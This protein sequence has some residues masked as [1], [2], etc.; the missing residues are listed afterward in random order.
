MAAARLLDLRKG[1][2]N[3]SEAPRELLARALGAVSARALNGEL[4]LAYGGERGSARYLRALRSFLGAAEPSSPSASSWLLTTSGCSHG[5]ELLASLL[6]RRGDVVVCES[7][8]YFLAGQVWRDHGL[9]V[10]TIESDAEGLRIDALAHA[11]EHEGLRP[12]LVCERLTVRWMSL[13]ALFDLL[14][15]LPSRSWLSDL[16]LDSPMPPRRAALPTFRHS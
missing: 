5:L 12:K 14:L 16:R 8:T 13:L 4:S 1:Y 10:A 7:P 6:C 15:A 3:P 11:I 9:R 2:P